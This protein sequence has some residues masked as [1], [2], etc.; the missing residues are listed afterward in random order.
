MVYML[1]IAATVRKSFETFGT[2]ERLL[3]AVQPSVLGEMVLMF[4]S[5]VTLG[6][7]VRTQI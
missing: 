5:L 2:L 6:A 1:R 3:S 7:F 4:E